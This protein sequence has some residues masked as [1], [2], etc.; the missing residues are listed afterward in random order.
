MYQKRSATYPV[1]CFNRRISVFISS[2]F[3]IP[4]VE[5]VLVFSRDSPQMPASPHGHVYDTTSPHI[6]GS[7]IEFTSLVFLGSDVWSA[8]AQTCGHVCFLFPGHAETFAVAEV[9][10]FESTVSC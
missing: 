3:Q 6:D 1:Q 4:L 9:G 5:F 7:R 2:S 10:D 8:T